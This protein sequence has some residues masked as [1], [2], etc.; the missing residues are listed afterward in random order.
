VLQ[1]EGL[2]FFS[3]HLEGLKSNPCASSLLFQKGCIYSEKNGTQMIAVFEALPICFTHIF[4][5][6]CTIPAEYHWRTHCGNKA[7][8]KF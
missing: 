2:P 7:K 5:D 8:Y 4:H 6:G 1:S 3:H